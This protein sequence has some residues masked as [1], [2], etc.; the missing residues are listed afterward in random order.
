MRFAVVAHS[1]S[2]TN[3]ALAGAAA[4]V[5]LPAS[6]LPPRDA[7]RFLEPGDVALGRLDVRE[8]LDGMEEGET[9]LERLAAGGV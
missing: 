2:E 3:E 8:A 1:R 6:V 9:D 5:G 4:S 7:L